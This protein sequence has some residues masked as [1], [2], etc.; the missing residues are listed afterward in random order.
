MTSE[1]PGH[2]RLGFSMEQKMNFPMG[3][4]NPVILKLERVL[5]RV[6]PAIVARQ[7]QRVLGLERRIMD[8]PVGRMYLDPVFDVGA[9]ISETGSHD[10]GM[11]RTLANELQR[12]MTFIDLGANEGYFTVQG[13]RLVGTVGRVVAVEPQDKLIPVIERNLALNDL[14]NVTV[15]RAAISDTDG[16]RTL[17]LPPGLSGASF[18]RMTRYPVPTQRTKT[19]TLASL[20]AHCGISDADVMKVDIEG[21]EYEAVLGSRE[22]FAAHRVK[23][24]AL[25]LHPAQLGIPRSRE[26]IAFIE[27]CGYRREMCYEN[28]VWRAPTTFRPDIG[29]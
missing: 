14:G 9:V 21:A 18:T 4:V 25:D 5:R 6:R 16:S 22:I 28:T 27:G 19:M 12:G 24:L 17:F 15:V 10:P 20:F 23:V 1:T 3:G 13:A 7:I 11:Q 8:T 26:L 2:R 29:R